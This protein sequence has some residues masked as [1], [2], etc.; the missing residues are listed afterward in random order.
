MAAQFAAIIDWMAAEW[1][2]GATQFSN[3]KGVFLRVI[4]CMP[5]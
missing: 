5:F 2:L 3:L 1:S 4:C